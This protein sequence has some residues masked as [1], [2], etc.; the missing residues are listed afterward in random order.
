LFEAAEFLASEAEESCRGRFGGRT[1]VAEEGMPPPRV[2]GEAVCVLLYLGRCVCM[3]P[4]RV[5]PGDGRAG[6]WPVWSTDMEWR[7]GTDMRPSWGCCRLALMAAGEG[8]MADMG[9]K[10]SV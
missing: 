8:V 5:P 1:E 4:R 10:Y 3:G 7:C 9:G 6:S 2:V